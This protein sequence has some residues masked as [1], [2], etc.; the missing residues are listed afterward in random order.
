MRM[1]IEHVLKVMVVPIFSMA[2]TVM[3]FTT[4]KLMKNTDTIKLTIWFDAPY[5]SATIPAIGENVVIMYA[6]AV[7]VNV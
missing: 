1:I 5:T 2:Y 7:V 6:D 3:K 4:T